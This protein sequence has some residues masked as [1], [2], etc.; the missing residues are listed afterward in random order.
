MKE[1]THRDDPR[2]RNDAYRVLKDAYVRASL[3]LTRPASREIQDKLSR[4]IE[5]HSNRQMRH[6]RDLARESYR[7]VEALVGLYSTLGF[8]LPLPPMRGYAL[9]PDAAAGIVRL[10]HESRPSTILELGS[11]VSTLITAYSLKRFGGGRVISFEH[12]AAWCEVTSGYIAQHDLGDYAEV[13]YAPIDE[14]EINGRLWKWY[15]PSA[16]QGIDSVDMLVVDGPPADT[17]PLAR[18]P[19]LPLV[20]HLLTDKAVIVLD[21]TGREDERSIIG[22][23]DAESGPFRIEDLPAEKGLTVMRR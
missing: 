1:P 12:D 4:V 17:Q 18:Y 13:R 15:D 9:S 10:I 22:M 20:A 16:L 2:V 6:A 23:W 5:H 19:A 14:A 21:D 8:S 3:R 11:G 7:Q